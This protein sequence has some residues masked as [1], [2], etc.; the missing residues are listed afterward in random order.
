MC[1]VIVIYIIVSGEKMP[2]TEG[3]VVWTPVFLKGLE[4]GAKFV[5]F[6]AVDEDGVS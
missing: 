6:V 2:G 3:V 1:V 4:A 5:G